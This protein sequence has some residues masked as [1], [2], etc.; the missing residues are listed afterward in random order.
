MKRSARGALLFVSLLVIALLGPVSPAAQRSPDTKDAAHSRLRRHDSIPRGSAASDLLLRKHRE[1]VSDQPQN[2]F[3]ADNFRLVGRLGLSAGDNADVFFYNHGGTAGK[4]VYVGNRC[5]STGVK[6]I[7]VNDPTNPRLVARVGLRAG[8]SNEDVVVRRIGNRDVLAVGVQPCTSPAPAGLRLFDV[9]T[10]KN[11]T[12]LGFLPQ[13]G[14]VHELDMVV[15]P[16]GRALALLA[17][18]F[19]EFGNTYLAPTPEASSASLT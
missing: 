10:P 15:R 1:P 4:H 6:I 16:D 13:P 11:P 8:V 9:T 2:T 7:N 3:A 17:E 19:V 14:G 18:P 12:P 5:G